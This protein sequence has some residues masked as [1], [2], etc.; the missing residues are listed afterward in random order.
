MTI[1]L[2]ESKT[3]D[4]RKLITNLLSIS[5]PTIRFVAKVVGTLVSTFPAVKYA[6]L[7]YRNIEKVKTHALV[8]NQGN[9]EAKCS[10][11]NEAKLE[12]NWW[13][14]ATLKNW[15]HPPNISVK[16]TC[17][18]STGGNSFVGA[19]GAV[20]NSVTCGGAW[21]L[22]EQTYHINIRELLAIY[23]ALKSFQSE[24]V[25]SHVKVLNDNVAAVGIVNK[26]GTSKSELGNAIA[27]NIWSFCEKYNIWVTA[28]H[29][30]GIDNTAADTESRRQYKEAE[31]KLDPK[32]FSE[33]CKTLLF[34]P[35]LDCFA[36]RLNCQLV[37]FVSFKPDPY[38]KFI[39]AFS[40]N[41][42]EFNCYIFPPFSLI[43]KVLQKI[44]IDQAKVM[45]VA[46]QWPSQPWYT[47]FRKMLISN[48]ITI[49]PRQGLLFLPQ[50]PE[51]IHPLSKN[52]TLMIGILSGIDI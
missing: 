38:A 41:W 2:S 14:T 32:I 30:P 22:V 24:C 6:A 10:L 50:S 23:Y 40:I 13:K 42:N 7:H 11:N 36:S 15:I 29:I 27:K 44:K 37:D 28:A 51:S 3:K 19:W 1:S 34:S 9:F 31:W 16:I 17:D 25:N 26:M 46:P 45:I 8:L 5:H 33:A 47:M 20:C 4:L 35:N 39:N 48:L 21:D 52:L 49:S 43:G 12:L 18:A